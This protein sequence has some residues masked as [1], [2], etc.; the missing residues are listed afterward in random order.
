MK[1]VRTGSYDRYFQCYRVQEYPYFGVIVVQNWSYSK[2]YLTYTHDGN[3]TLF[4]KLEEA[5]RDVLGV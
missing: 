5:Y 2:N 3:D 4:Y 1:W